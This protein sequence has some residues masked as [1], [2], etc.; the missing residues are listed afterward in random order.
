MTNFNNLLHSILRFESDPEFA[1]SRAMDELATRFGAQTAT[2]HRFDPGRQMLV[3]AA[4]VGLPPHIAAITKEI[5]L[6]KGI[7][8]EAAATRK[9]VTM[10]N[11][12]TDASGVAKPAAKQTGVGGALCV[13]IE[14]DGELV[15]TIG[16]GTT[17]EYNYTEEETRALAA[18]GRVFGDCLLTAVR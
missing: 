15:G 18:A 5:P 10:C 14:R 9:P 11:L 1:L 8:G 6:G 17:R 12:Q 16:V 13:P 3:M 4:S 7:A 2:L